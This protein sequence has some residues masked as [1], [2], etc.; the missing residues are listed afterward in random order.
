[1]EGN[2]DTPYWRYCLVC[3][4]FLSTNYTEYF[5]AVIRINRMKCDF[6]GYGFLIFNFPLPCYLSISQTETV[7]CMKCGVMFVRWRNVPLKFCE[8][9]MVAIHHFVSEIFKRPWPKCKLSKRLL[10]SGTVPETSNLSL[11]LSWLTQT[12]TL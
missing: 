3:I 11:K 10:A 12:A 9:T 5:L 7:S 8:F 1:M 2:T 6:Y 4:P